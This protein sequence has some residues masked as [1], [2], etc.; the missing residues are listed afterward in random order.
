MSK[1]TSK[2]SRHHVACNLTFNPVCFALSLK[3]N[4]FRIFDSNF[5]LTTSLL[6]CG[7]DFSCYSFVSLVVHDDPLFALKIESMLDGESSQNLFI[8]ANYLIIS[9]DERSG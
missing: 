9:E 3:L 6:H 5:Q 7:D 1:V 8:T 2:S 4:E